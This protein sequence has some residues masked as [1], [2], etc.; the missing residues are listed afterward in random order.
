MS[1]SVYDSASADGKVALLWIGDADTWTTLSALSQ[2]A[3]KLGLGGTRAQQVRVLNGIF[4]DL[5][6]TPRQVWKGGVSTYEWAF[7][8]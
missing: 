1:D 4:R 3:P 8:A 2:L 7:L 5:G 6:A